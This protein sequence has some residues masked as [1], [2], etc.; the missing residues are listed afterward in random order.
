MLGRWLL[1]LLAA[2]VVGYCGVALALYFGQRQIL[3]R[4]DVTRPDAAAVG[5]PGLR[6]VTLRT[7]G[8]LELVAWWLPPAAPER[9]VLLYF[10]GNGGN[11]AH[12]GERLR[13]F[14]AAG[15][16]ALMPEYPGY[17][18][19]PGAPSERS[20]FETATA[21]LAFLQAQAVRDGDVA[22]YGESLG[23][24]VAAWL[25]AGRRVRALVLESPF[26]SV[27][28]LAQA[29]YWFLP[30]KWLVRDPFDT[31]GRIGRAEA[32]VLVA[33]GERDQVVPP[34]MGRAVFAAAPAPKRLWAAAD[35]GHEDLARFGLIEAVI[36]F[37]RRD[38]AA[39][40]GAE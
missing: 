37:L 18:G 6:A 38:A 10:H 15:F 29:L 5:V 36:E 34:W 30:V 11:L 14:A 9:T 27:T 20:L 12:R 22:V 35:G 4:P 19:N 21:A 3:F 17:G 1:G 40:T 16:G 7:A 28:A 32:P 33:L 24:G 39:A 26:T 25:A 2:A 13:R 23:T 8:G 31:L